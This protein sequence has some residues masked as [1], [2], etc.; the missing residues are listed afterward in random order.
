MNAKWTL[1]FLFTFFLSFGSQAYD[2]EELTELSALFMEAVD[3][4]T[5]TR[6]TPKLGRMSALAA[7]NA[8]P[9]TTKFM[10]ELALSRMEVKEQ[11][12]PETTELFGDKIDLNTGSVMFQQTDLSLKG[13]SSLPVSVSRTYRGSKNNRGNNASFGDWVLDIPS[14]S[15]T[16]LE[17]QPGL[18]SFIPSCTSASPNW[19]DTGF[20]TV[21]AMQYWSG[22]T[23]EIPGVTS[24][25]IRM[26]YGSGGQQLQARFADNWKISCL[27]N[28]YGFEA[29][30]PEGT[31]YTFD[32]IRLVPS[33]FIS[34]KQEA[35]YL[36]PNYDAAVLLRTYTLNVQVSQIRDRLTIQSILSMSHPHFPM[37]AQASF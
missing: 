15:T 12:T 32:V 24:Q 18:L 14:I 23:I 4:S 27:T 19:V 26:A 17:Y 29:T 7:S 30:S 34:V 35:E 3:P 25:K 20:A 33:S 16:T 37:A 31:V 21:G 13:N 28:R 11:I 22:T 10:T 8:T 5:G 6:P 9:S 2:E 1:T 36:N